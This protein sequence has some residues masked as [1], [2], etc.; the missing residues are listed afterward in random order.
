MVPLISPRRPRRPNRRRDFATLNHRAPVVTRKLSRAYHH[1]PK[2]PWRVWLWLGVIIFLGGLVIG[3][4]YSPW[5]TIRNVIVNNVGFKPTEERL[6][7]IVAE[8]MSVRRWYILPQSNLFFFSVKRARQILA[9]EFYIEDVSF[10]RHWPNVL[11]INVANN[12]MVGI[13]QATN[14]DFLMDRR[15]V[16][17]QQLLESTSEASS[18]PVVRETDGPERNLGDAV[19]SAELAGFIDELY[20]AWQTRLPELSPEYIVVETHSLPTLQV[21]LPAGWYVNVTGESDAGLQ[22]ESLGRILEERIKDDIS[23]LQ[24]VDVR[25]GNRLYFKLK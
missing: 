7:E 19:A 22:I 13:W 2:S 18:L 25:F 6:V 12:V 17:V 1:E 11:K 21:Y 5:F 4:I 10:V 14:G 16:L 15:G 20:D 24:Y 23:K 8:A 3:L 9:A